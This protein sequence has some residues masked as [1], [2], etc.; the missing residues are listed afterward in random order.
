MP[1]TPVIV[2]GTCTGADATYKVI[3]YN[4]TESKSCSGSINGSGLYLIDL[5]NCDYSLGDVIYVRI[6]KVNKASSDSFTVTQTMIDDG[7]YQL[8]LTMGDVR[9]HIF[10]VLYNLLNANKPDAFIDVNSED[11]ITWSVVSSFAKDSPNLPQIVIYPTMI[12]H[13]FVDMKNSTQDI[14]AV[15]E[16]MFYSK[17]KYKKSRIDNGRGSIADTIIANQSILEFLGMYFDTPDF[18]EDSNVD[19][20]ELG[21]Q[22]YNIATQV[23]NFN[24][25]P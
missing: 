22:T 13:S 12:T 3:A 11:E 23:Y 18:I 15:V 4:S 7:N 16:I 14:P 1:S 5:L 6:Y 20:L 17:L 24:W 19:E 8:N 9:E 2:N 10:K 21:E 25:R